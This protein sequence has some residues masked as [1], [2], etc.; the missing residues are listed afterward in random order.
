MVITLKNYIFVKKE[1]ILSRWKKGNRMKTIHKTGVKFLIV[2]AVLLGFTN[3]LAANGCTTKLFSVTIDSKLTIG[4]VIDNLADTCG[5]TVIV[6]DDAAKLRMNKNLYYV[7]LKNSTLKGF[8]NTVLKDNDLH[9]SLR[10]NK[11][12]ISYLLTRTFRIHYISGQRTGKSTA[13]VTI[14]NSNNSAAGNNG[15]GGGGADGAGS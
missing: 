6:Q 4:D 14:A 1:I 12:K 8:L 5:L 3:N 11:L 7:K 2:F 10:G 9:Y 13:N 15:G